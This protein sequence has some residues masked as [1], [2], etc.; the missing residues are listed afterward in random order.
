MERHERAA[1]C[2]ADAL[3]GHEGCLAPLP[4]RFANSH[5]EAI[6][7]RE[8]ARATVPV[9]TCHSKDGCSRSA[10]IFAETERAARRGEER[11]SRL[12]IGHK[13]GCVINH[14]APAAWFSTATVRERSGS[15]GFG[16]AV[17]A[18][19]HVVHRAVPR[20]LCP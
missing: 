8:L 6:R 1:D 7:S 19:K 17:L 11:Y 15:L 14:A 16:I 10:V 3:V 18:E 9:A 2:G 20:G 5:P 13:L 12:T 4:I